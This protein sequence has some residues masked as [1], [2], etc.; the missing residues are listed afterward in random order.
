MQP[1]CSGWLRALLQVVTPL[2]PSKGCTVWNVAG[3]RGR[4]NKNMGKQASAYRPSITSAH[5][6]LTK[7]SFMATAK[8]KEAEK[9]SSI[10]CP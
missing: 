4:R 3:H 1:L 7:A 8:F 6:S 10:M 2:D 9:C 5:I